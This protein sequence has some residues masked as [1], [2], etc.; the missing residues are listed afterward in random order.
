MWFSIALE[1]VYGLVGQA[2][3]FDPPEGHYRSR[4]N[5]SQPCD[6]SSTFASPHRGRLFCAQ[7]LVLLAVRPIYLSKESV[8]PMP[9][10]IEQ[11]TNA[12]DFGFFGGMGMVPW[13]RQV[14]RAIIGRHLA[15]HDG[16]EVDEVPP[17]T[18]YSANRGTGQ[19]T[20][21]HKGENVVKM[22]QVQELLD[23]AQQA[24]RCGVFIAPIMDTP[25]FGTM[26][27]DSRGAYYKYSVDHALKANLNR[28]S[29][30]Y[31]ELN[32]LVEQFEAEEV[33]K[34]RVAA[35]RGTGLDVKDLAHV[36]RYV[37]EKGFGALPAA[38]RL[39]NESDD[40]R[41]QRLVDMLI[42]HVPFSAE[43]EEKARAKARDDHG[44]SV[45]MR[46]EFVEY[47]QSLDRS[48]VYLIVQEDARHRAVILDEVIPDMAM[49]MHRIVDCRKASAKFAK[50]SREYAHDAVRGAEALE[51]QYGDYC[52]ARQQPPELTEE[53]DNGYAAA[54]A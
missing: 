34:Q 39:D 29:I 5:A 15:N 44:K 16:Q 53:R 12:A 32:P 40:E 20:P 19:W 38:M 30:L 52:V 28:F 49:K 13:H 4:L 46:K 10:R 8:L 50:Y 43:Q 24:E 47:I 6:L 42:E 26:D 18:T 22:G 33:Y 31:V 45:A 27:R 51:A 23:E 35:L 36:E 7:V 1:S 54:R 25:C 14:E 48:D 2:T 11:M 9:V 21:N 3:L 37:A 17:L 41:R